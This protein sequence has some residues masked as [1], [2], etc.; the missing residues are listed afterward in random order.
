VIDLYVL[1]RMLVLLHAAVFCHL[2]GDYVLQSS[3]MAKNKVRSHA[4]AGT[5]ALM[6]GLPFAF[7]IPFGLT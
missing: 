3:W 2:I 7:L 5:H 1:V 4:A 6:Y